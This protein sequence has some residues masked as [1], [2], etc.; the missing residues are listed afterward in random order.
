ML[1]TAMHWLGFGLCHQLADRS[2][3]AGGV[4]LPVCARDTGIY[5]GFVVS[6]A[7]IA[8]VDR[9][10]RH[11]DM[12]PAWI[13]GIGVAA[14][15]FMA[16]DG[17]TSYMGLRETTN[18]L[19]LASGLGA[20]FALPLVMVP[21]VNS[22]LWV[23]PGTGRV[24]GEPWKGLVWFAAAPATLGVLVWGAPLLGAGY[25]VVTAICILVTFSAVNLIVIASVPRFE[26]SAARLR[27]AWPAILLA[28]TVTVIEFA[29]ADWLRLA[30]SSIVQQ[31]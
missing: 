27:D 22:G 13:L 5:I 31:R 12:P 25:A 19:R 11:Q 2:F 4:Q 3:T 14:L 18:L 23:R 29:L 10:R 7:V 9:G 28:L 15:A 8:L 16:W 24:L 21:T 17:L 30:L 1:E 6:L 20:G 26:R